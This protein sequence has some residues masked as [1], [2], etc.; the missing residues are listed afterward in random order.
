MKYMHQSFFCPPHSTLIA[1]IDNGQLKGCPF[2]TADNVRKYLPASPATS[3]ERMK[4]PQTGIRST[5]P[6]NTT[7]DHERIIYMIP[8]P[9]SSSKVVIKNTTEANSIPTHSPIT[10][11]FEDESSNGQVNNIFCYA[12]LVDIRTGTFY[13]TSNLSGWPSI[14]FHRI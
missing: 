13:T 14:L 8:T 10:I 12:A 3:K 9:K 11:P 6:K 7:K 1:A 2:M 5:R 4:R